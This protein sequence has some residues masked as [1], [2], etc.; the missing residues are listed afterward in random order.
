M[1]RVFIP[2]LV[3]ALAAPSAARAEADALSAALQATAPSVL[4][5]VRKTGSKNVGVVEGLV[6]G[7]DGALTAH[8][9]DMNSSLA[10]PTQVALVLANTDEDF[11][12][13]DIPREF[14][15]REKL[16]AAN[17]RTVEGRRAFFTIGRKYEL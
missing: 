13:I 9:G 8:A 15:A 10:K 2:A 5:H 6:G 11:G 14:I 3:L 16:S 4:A 17:H 12:I 1:S 7:E